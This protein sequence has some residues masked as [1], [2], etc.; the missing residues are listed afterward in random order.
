[1]CDFDGGIGGIGGGIVLEVVH[2]VGG[3][4]SWGKA[5]FMGIQ[6]HR[7][8]LSST[9]ITTTPLVYWRTHNMQKIC[10]MDQCIRAVLLTFI[11]NV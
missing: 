2:V 7:L 11:I 1:M 4:A 9:T 3:V 6:I 8:L 10:L 5:Y